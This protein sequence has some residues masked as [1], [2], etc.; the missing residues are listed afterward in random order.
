MIFPHVIDNTMRKV[1]V[2]CQMAAHYKY[3]LGL[4][5]P[6]DSRVDLV[7]GKAFARGIEVARRVYF[8]EHKS[9]EEAER[10]G[11]L[12]LFDSYGSFVPP[13]DSNKTAARMAGALSYY[14]QQR[15][16]QEENLVPIVAPDGQLAVEMSLSYP[17][18]VA[19]PDDGVVLEYAGNFDMLAL[20]LK[21]GGAWIVDE[22]TTSQMGPK[23][24]NQWPLDS[25]MTGYVWLA[26]K[27]L[28][29]H[30]LKY[31]IKG[32]IINGIAIRKHEYEVG[33]FPTYREPWEVNRWFDQLQV[34]VEN[35]K[36]AYASKRWNQ[37]LDHACAY[38]LNPCEFVP[39]CKAKQP[40]K[41]MGTY[42]VEFWN[43]KDRK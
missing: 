14:L 33:R 28:A 7:A 22:K 19:H 5:D 38:Y 15:P 39:L 41:L 2:K 13:S 35:W 31:E 26:Q 8:H 6:D 40:E 1:L 10:Q 37:N 34:D 18:G 20:D 24:A 9:A 29:E 11:V 23:W 16:F 36:L 32:A 42:R 21:T 4:N 27:W 43:P 30:D 17:M 12:A 3:E 25:Q